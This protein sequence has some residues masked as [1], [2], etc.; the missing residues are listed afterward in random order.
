[1]PI[2]CRLS[3]ST[4]VSESAIPCSVS[5]FSVT[6]DVILS[7]SISFCCY[8]KK[9]SSNKFWFTSMKLTKWFSSDRDLSPFWWIIIHLYTCSLAYTSGRVIRNFTRSK[10]PK[11]ALLLLALRVNSSVYWE[12]RWFWDK[13]KSSFNAIIWATNLSLLMRI[14]VYYQGNINS[15]IINVMYRCNNE[16]TYEIPSRCKFIL[17]SRIAGF[18]LHSY[19]KPPIHHRVLHLHLGVKAYTGSAYW[20][21]YLTT[22][23]ILKLPILG[24]RNE[25]D[26]NID[27]RLKKL[28]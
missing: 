15:F 17:I 19:K 13:V 5:L 14:I 16:S 9:L 2:M 1:M 12:V 4:G 28:T 26:V 18:Q 22:L 11:D 8:E 27:I 23:Y 20:S 25:I 10:N 3:T 24:L 7:M 21:H 6:T